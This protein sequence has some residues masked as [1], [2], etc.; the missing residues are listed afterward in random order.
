MVREAMTWNSA[1]LTPT[2]MQPIT[3]TADMASI[4]RALGFSPRQ[5]TSTKVKTRISAGPASACCPVTR[6]MKASTMA[7]R[8]NAMGIAPRSPVPSGVGS[9]IIVQ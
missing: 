1:Q 7:G 3:T 5:P 4:I 2:A 6:S 9:D 8:I